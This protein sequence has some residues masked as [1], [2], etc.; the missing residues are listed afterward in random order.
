M[1]NYTK[2]EKLKKYR[3]SNKLSLSLRERNNS[4]FIANS[5]NLFGVFSVEEVT[6]LVI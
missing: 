1:K 5:Q 4:G 3:M 2:V 6:D